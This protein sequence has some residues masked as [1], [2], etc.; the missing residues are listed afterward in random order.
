[1]GQLS[2]FMKTFQCGV[3]LGLPFRPPPSSTDAVPPRY[4]DPTAVDFV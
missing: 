1:M 3:S 4:D 2:L